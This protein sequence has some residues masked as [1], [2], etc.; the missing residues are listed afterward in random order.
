MKYHI[1]RSDEKLGEFNDLDIAAGMRR[2]EFLP[3][4]L[5]WAKGMTDWEP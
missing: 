1:A 5:C 3:T 4:D 2:G